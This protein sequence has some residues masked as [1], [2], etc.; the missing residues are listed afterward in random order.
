[1]RR[2]IISKK[3]FARMFNILDMPQEIVD[4]LGRINTAYREASEEELQEY[5]S[6]V[7]SL[8]DSPRIVRRTQENYEAWERGWGEQ[9]QELAGSSITVSDLK[10]KY[11]RP[12]K[13]FRYNKTIIIP[14]NPHLEYDLFTIARHILFF[15][16]LSNAEFAY[17]L[18]CGS[19]QNLL[20]LHQLF[21]S[22]RLV[23]LDWAPS[24]IKIAEQLHAQV[25][26]NISGMLFDMAHPL[27]DV[28][29]DGSCAV[30]S[31]HALEQ[32]GVQ[33]E[34][35]LSFLL[36]ARPGLVLH[37]E[38]IL[39]FYDQD[40][41]LDQLAYRYSMKRNYLFGFF[42]SLCQLRDAGKIEILKAYRPFLGGVIHEASV[43]AWRPF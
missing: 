30:F 17:E 2:G 19:C 43:I 40:N 33:H 38:P 7:S 23:G 29:L 8:I 37:Y 24:S 28:R 3:D 6:W 11:F 13:F 22:K 34:E 35:L 32:L 10:P 12:N 5:I 36:E 9:S 21:S 14:D 39:E 15:Q 1:M 42:K 20:S 31:V 25:S 27:A 26:G 4:S 18:G 41:I 16:F